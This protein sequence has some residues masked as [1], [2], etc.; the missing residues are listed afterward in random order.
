MLLGILILES[1]YMQNMILPGLDAP[2]ASKE[3]VSNT[4]R[5]NVFLNKNMERFMTEV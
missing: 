2:I 3:T 5:G 4:L 1:L